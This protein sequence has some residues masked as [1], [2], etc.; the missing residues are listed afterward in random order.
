MAVSVVPAVLLLQACLATLPSQCV[1]VLNDFIRV[2]VA[3]D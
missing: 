2:E 1:P 3:L